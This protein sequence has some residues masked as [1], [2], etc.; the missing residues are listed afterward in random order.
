MS[1]E[2]QQRRA[3]RDREMAIRSAARAAEAERT[4]RRAA[5][6]RALTSWLPTRGPRQS[7]II[8][9]RRRRQLGATVALLLPANV[10]V[11]VFFEDWSARAMV[12]VVSLLAAPVL[13]TMM[14]RR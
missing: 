2:R 3:E 5:R 6:R 13:H 1:K 8:A 10:L 11:W 14:F 4:E 12:A 7:G 9:E